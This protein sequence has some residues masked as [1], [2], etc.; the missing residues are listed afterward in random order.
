MYVRQLAYSYSPIRSQIA[1]ELAG[2]ALIDVK[3]PKGGQKLES[4]KDA[5]YELELPDEHIAPGYM[6]DYNE[7]EAKIYNQ[8]VEMYV[9]YKWRKLAELLEAKV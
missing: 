9:N 5:L 6:G 2:H 4:I 1:L 3:L 8:F 7:E